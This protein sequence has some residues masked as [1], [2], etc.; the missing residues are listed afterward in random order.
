MGLLLTVASSIIKVKVCEFAQRYGEKRI[1]PPM[2]LLRLALSGWKLNRSTNIALLLAVATTT[3]VLTGALLVGDSV[4]GS[5]RDLIL[6]RL[7]RVDQM[8]LTD[9]FFG[10]NLSAQLQ[11][12]ADFNQNGMLAESVILARGSL[13]NPGQERI[14]SDVTVFGCQ[15]NVL[16]V[17][18][19]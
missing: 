6:G 2:N 14:V 7:G 18:K 15:H 11:S 12:R 5:L 10:E 17:G 4:T 9:V 8:V 13:K 19:F 1:I 16:I 3:T